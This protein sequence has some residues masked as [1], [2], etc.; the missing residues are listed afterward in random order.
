MGDVALSA[1]YSVAT[2]DIGG[3]TA[4]VVLHGSAG[5]VFTGSEGDA[6]QEAA[7]PSREARVLLLAAA[8][9]TPALNRYVIRTV[10]QQIAVGEPFEFDVDAAR[11]A[12]RLI[13]AHPSVVAI[14]G[15]TTWISAAGDAPGRSMPMWTASPFGVPAGSPAPRPRRAALAV[16]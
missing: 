6:L 9:A 11:L 8:G 5:K 13:A 12:V 4:S 1:G 15:E 14:V 7:R 16:A 10:R 2:V 3:R